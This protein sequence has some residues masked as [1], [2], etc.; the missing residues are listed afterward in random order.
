[1][2]QARGPPVLRHDGAMPPRQDWREMMQQ[3]AEL[4]ERRTGQGVPEWRARITQQA[5]S[6]E[7]TLR[8]WLK[9]Q[10]VEGY[11]QQLL[12][13]ETFGYPDFLTATADDL[14]GAQYADRPALRPTLDRLIEV[15]GSLG[16]VTVQARKGFVTLQTERRKFAVIKPA[17]KTRV[18]LGLR[19]DTPPGNQRFQPADPGRSNDMRTK[20]GLTQPGDVDQDVTD[21]LRQAYAE[22]Q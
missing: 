19:I 2:G 20:V 21:A 6:D 17:T 9:G 10:G 5:P 15:A 13:F 8:A 18:D 12:V 3:H 7:A 22:N 4:L 16:T 14:I 11:P 1:M